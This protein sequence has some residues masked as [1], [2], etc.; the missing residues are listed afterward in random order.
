[1][2]RI[3]E[4]W[5]WPWYFARNIVII[6]NRMKEYYIEH[7][8]LTGNVTLWQ[9]MYVFDSKLFFLEEIFDSYKKYSVHSVTF[10]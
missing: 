9:E 10:S 7:T 3:V 5:L 1:M 4:V 8:I 2:A 6:Y